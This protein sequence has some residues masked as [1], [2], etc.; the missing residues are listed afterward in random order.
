MNSIRVLHARWLMVIAALEVLAIIGLL[1][2]VIAIRKDAVPQVSKPTVMQ[3]VIPEPTKTYQTPKVELKLF[4]SGLNTPTD[5]AAPVDTSETQLFVTE[6]PGTIRIV[7]SNGSLDGKPFLDITTKVQDD[8]G[9]KGLLGIAFHPKYHDNGFF[10]VNYV[11]K[12]D[13]STIA[14]Y[15]VS[16]QTGLADPASE[17]ILL[18]L[19]KPYGNHNGG[20]LEFGPDGYL[21]AGTGDG[22]AAGDPQNRA[23]N[24]TGSLFG[25]IL[26]LDVDHGDPYS[27]P[28]SNPFENGG[29]KSEVW[30]YGL[31]NP[32]RLGF[33]RKT[34]DLYIAD[35]GQGDYEEINVQPAASKG[36][37]NYGWRCY[38]GLHEYN[39]EGCQSADNY[40]KPI[41]EFD[42]AEGRCSVTGGYVYRGLTFPALTG[43]YFFGDYCGG[44]VYYAEQIDNAWRTTVANVTNDYAIST[45]GEDSAGELYLA[46]LIAGKLYQIQ[47]SAN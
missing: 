16:K 45:F 46:D 31:R 18:K 43:K 15:H 30:A 20:S 39:K 34:G 2:W 6:R 37:E 32:W 12:S 25:K 24:K 14:R 40:I 22:G 44:Q 11:D 5:I 35:V 3:Q 8:K 19:K 1:I 29:K 21:Y 47:D 36:G 17:K 9:E 10:F 7:N 33:D 4:A 28:A 27:V 41:V 42:H 38:E 13:N 26:R 23:Q